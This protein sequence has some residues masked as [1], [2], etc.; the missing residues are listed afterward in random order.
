MAFITPVTSTLISPV[1]S[2]TMPL[3]VLG[4]GV[5]YAQF[6]HSLG[7]YNYGAE[8]FYMSA[9]NFQQIGQAFNYN[10]FDANGNSV[11]TFLPFAVD[12]YQSQ[13][14][15]FYEVNS[16]EIIFTNL[17]SMQLVVEPNTTL[18]FKFF[19][20]IT[21]LGNELDDKKDESGFDLFTE[22][23]RRESVNFFSNY[24]DYLI[25]EDLNYGN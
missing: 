22:I 23:E 4:N 6:L 15:I 7:A 14:S 10:H 11:T 19:A 5:T 2:V 13:P 1:I 16:D 21:Y 24:C 18:Y 12:P 20:T 17:S 8:F 3:Q 9:T 25:D